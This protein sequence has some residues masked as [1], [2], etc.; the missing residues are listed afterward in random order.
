MKDITT[1]LTAIL[2]LFLVSCG[3]RKHDINLLKQAETLLKSSPDSALLLLDSIQEPLDLS[4]K[5]LAR[6]S[7]LVS[8]VRDKKE[9]KMLSD[10]ILAEAFSYW[11]RHGTRLEKSRMALFLGRSYFEAKE[12][13]K[14]LEQYT[15]ALEEADEAKEYNQAGYICTYMADVYDTQDLIEKLIEKYTE[16]IH[17]FSLAGNKRSMAIAYSNLAF[18]FIQNAKYD[19][20]LECCDKADSISVLL[21]DSLVRGSI[22]N[23]KGIAYT[24]LKEY[25]LAEHYTLE[26]HKWFNGD[27]EGVYY[28]LA[29]IYIEIGKLEKAKELYEYYQTLDMDRKDNSDLYYWEYLFNKKQEKWEKALEYFEKYQAI[30]DSIEEQKDE[31]AILKVERKYQ[32]SKVLNENQQLKI[33]SLWG[34]ILLFFVVSTCLFLCIIY[35]HSRKQKLQIKQDLDNHQILLLNKEL[36]L[37]RKVALFEKSIEE[38][39]EEK[40]ALL[41]EHSSLEKEDNASPTHEKE[42]YIDMYEKEVQEL[43]QEVVSM[44]L[45][46]LKSTAI[47]KKLIKLSE[48][49]TINQTASLISPKDWSTLKKEV[50]NIYHNYE[51]R[52]KE[53]VPALTNDDI[54]FCIL[55]LLD[56]DLKGLA[57]LLNIN[58]DSVHKKRFRI[59]ERAK[60]P[61][62]NGDLDVF[63]R[64]I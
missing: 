62:E 28:S 58:V 16:A 14:A 38:L 63:I 15:Y 37:Q 55:S 41:R 10:T 32:Y 7:M 25:K 44:Q 22:F 8:E 5:N 40:E 59:K 39:K 18:D 24:E 56:I 6:W 9:E 57:C 20:A 54:D 33:R 35:L 3:D 49:P 47:A 30:V 61:K 51:E 52:F 13:E 64:N 42:D 34:T 23:I 46:L 17:Y 12:Y 43:K 1:I 50:N 29:T 11:K 26:A 31:E 53:K 45:Q 48:K 2:L 60:L 21:N 19:K 4:T 36:E 27:H